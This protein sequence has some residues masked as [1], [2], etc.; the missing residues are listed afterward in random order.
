LFQ[1]RAEGSGPFLWAEGVPGAKMY[2]IM[3]VQYGNSVMSQR[4]VCEWIESFK[5][6][7][8][9]LKHGEGTRRQSTSITVADMERVYGMILQNRRVTVNEV[10][11]QLQINHGSAY[12]SIHN[13]HAF[14]KVCAR[15]VPE[16][17]TELHKEKCLDVC[18]WLVDRCCAE[19][20]HFLER[21]VT[22][23]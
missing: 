8:T 11:H 18:K 9:S 2:R 5:N 3:S 1:R 20:D 15:W 21:M 14:H 6:G 7:R 19:D 17:V 10:A 22:G 4:I 13:R 12:E 23:N 16:Q